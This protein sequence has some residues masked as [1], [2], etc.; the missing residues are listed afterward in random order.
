MEEMMNKAVLE[1]SGAGPISLARRMHS[2]IGREPQRKSGE[3]KD[4]REEMEWGKLV[5]EVKNFAFIF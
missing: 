1:C 3:G 2:S 4:E 5:S